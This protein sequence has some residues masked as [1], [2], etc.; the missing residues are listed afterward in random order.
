MVS[1]VGKG[2]KLEVGVGNCV[3]GESVV[4]VGNCVNCVCGESVDKACVTGD[5]GNVNGWRIAG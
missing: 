3:C 5:G 4:G 1:Y 2:V